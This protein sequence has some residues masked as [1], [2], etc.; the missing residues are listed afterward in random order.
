MYWDEGNSKA[1]SPR[2][3]HDG[4]QH[5][6]LIIK[7]MPMPS[8]AGDMTGGMGMP[9]A[10]PKSAIGVMMDETDSMIQALA[11]HMASI[12]QL[13][14]QSRA[15]GIDTETT[16][17]MQGDMEKMRQ[18][19]LSLLQDVGMIKEMHASLNQHG[20]PVNDP[21]LAASMQQEPMNMP[22]AMPPQDAATMP[23]QAM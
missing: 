19:Q 9:P 11:D 18:K 14:S 4:E 15:T 10:P 1:V 12:G 17:R 16:L 3:R 6:G 8:P 5:N 7:Q 13:L 22:Q 20:P 23:Q 2:F 21:M